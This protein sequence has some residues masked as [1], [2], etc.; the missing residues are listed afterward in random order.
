MMGTHPNMG[1]EYV[2]LPWL[3][4][5]RSIGPSFFLECVRGWV[6]R[7]SDVSEPQT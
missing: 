6:F 2:P 1:P 7:A 5:I 4:G 3:K